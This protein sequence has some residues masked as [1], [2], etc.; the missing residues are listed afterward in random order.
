[1]LGFAFLSEPLVAAQLLGMGL[2][3]AGMAVIDGRLTRR[4]F[5]SANA[6]RQSGILGKPVLERPHD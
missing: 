1:L 3:I 2:I 5:G 4:F 6:T